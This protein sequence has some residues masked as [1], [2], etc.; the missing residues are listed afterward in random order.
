VSPSALSQT[1]RALEG[2]MGVRLLNAPRG[3]W[4]HRARCKFLE[5]VRRA[6]ANRSAFHELDDVRGRPSGTLRLNVSRIGALWW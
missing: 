6:S 3:T 1:L 4:A 2:R 5:R